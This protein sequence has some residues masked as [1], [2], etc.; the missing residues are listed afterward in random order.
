MNRNRPWLRVAAAE[1]EVVEFRPRRNLAQPPA[2]RGRTI[3]PIGAN[4]AAIFT[5]LAN[6][7]AAL[8]DPNVAPGATNPPIIF[9]PPATLTAVTTEVWIVATGGPNWGG[10]NVY[11][12]TDNATYALAGAIHKGGRQGTLTAPLPSAAD[13]DLADTLA[14][15]LSE[16]AGQLLSGTR[17]D[18]DNFVTLCYCDGELISY[19]TATLTAASKYN[20]TY[21]RRGVYGTTIATHSAGA[22]F[23]RIGPADPSLLRYDYPPSFIG[24]VIYIKL[25]AFNVF[26]G[27]AES[28]ANVVA[29]AYSLSGHG[30]IGV[31]GPSPAPVVPFVP[32]IRRLRPALDETDEDDWQPVRRFAPPGAPVPFRRRVWIPEAEEEE[33]WR[34]G[35]E[36]RP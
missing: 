21:L 3:A 24:G 20:L 1:E 8:Y 18:A 26:G 22:K 32:S 10:C 13:P 23:A 5:R 36:H 2:A 6:A 35:R 14:V 9:E 29:Y 25:P 4:G 12:S 7:G 33:I 34:P 15:D 30:L 16:S 28:L 19:Q 17:A 27:A 31:Y 11:T